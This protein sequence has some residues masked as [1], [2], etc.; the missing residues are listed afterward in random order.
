MSAVQAIPR[1]GLIWLLVAQVLVILPH[2]GHLP[3]WIIGLW[4]ACAA[5]RVQ[6]FRM[7]ARYPSGWVKAL[8]MIGAGLGVYLSR[9]GLIGLDAG[10]VL[11]IAAFILKL[12]EMRSC[13]DGWVLIFLGFFAVTTSYLFND[14]LLAGLYSLLP[15]TA[16]LAA[17][18]GLQQSG[19]STH[20]W[21][22][23]R[24]AGAL[25][26]QAVPLM[27]V[28]FVL[29]PRLGPLWTLPQPKDRGVTG[30][31]DSMS[32]GDIAELS[33]SAELAFR[34]NF[35]GPIP[36]REQLYWRAVT[37]ERFDGR[38]WSQSLASQVPQAPDWTP[39]GAPVRYSVVMQPSGRPWLYAL[40]VPQFEAGG[41]RLMPDFHVQRHR[42]VEQALL[43][44]A[45]SW[46]EALR[47]PVATAA[48]LERALQLPEQ[49]N[50]RSRAWAA[51][52]RREHASASAIVQTVL[53]HFNRQPYRYTLKPSA[54]GADIVDGFL[55]D[56]QNGF[57]IHYA[58]A[59][60]FVLRAAGV[61]ARVVAGYQGG[62]LNPAGNYL[63][64]RQLDAHAWVEYWRPEQGW[65]AIDPTFQ[66]APERIELGLEHALAGERE[67]IEDSPLALRRYRDIGWL[68]QLRLGWDNLNYGWQRW[69]LGYQG[70]RQ[71]GLLKRLFSQLDAGKLGVFTVLASALLLAVMALL[72]LKPWRR[73]RD[74][75]LR[76][77]RRFERLLARQGI[78]R[79]VGE[80]ERDFAIR[81]ALQMPAAAESIG[82]FARLYEGARYAERP[83]SER[84]L[85]LSLTRV[86]RQL[87]WRIRATRAQ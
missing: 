33:R 64:V 25:L 79:Q 38:R 30:L 56:T 54:V 28:L 58:G 24:L 21:A 71:L 5:W 8:L 40:D 51:A 57:C 70:E 22:T 39:R 10:V 53:R 15:V 48:V 35:E 9:G 14:S 52:L 66:V 81:A 65:V 27:L 7:R 18:I 31:A 29:F 1:D 85:Q 80:G 34:V 16:L 67:L 86:R 55:F 4:L 44:Q 26:L 74:A 47:E 36:A 78:D 73:E 87:P 37:F 20:S 32:P 45:T 42:P 68:N 72:L 82:D 17:M 50:P 3:I 77:F 12:V 2:L 83:V 75:Q 69:V 61:P 63:T 62:E 13:R 19:S 84:E 43:Y 59:M 6:I 46:P 23:L 60:T 41:A 49:G 76:L 11:L